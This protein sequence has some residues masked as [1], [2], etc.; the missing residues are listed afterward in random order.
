MCL[1]T[2][3]YVSLVYEC[4]WF[5]FL[6]NELILDSSCGCQLSMYRDNFIFIFLGLFVYEYVI[7]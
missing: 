2:R 6:A 3:T 7:G 1:Y 4:E 5:V